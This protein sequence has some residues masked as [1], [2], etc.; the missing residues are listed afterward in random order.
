MKYL[1]N[2]EK[3]AF[4]RG[5]YIGYS[6]GVWRVRKRGAGGWE[7]EKFYPMTRT[8]NRDFPLIAAPTLEAMSTK[9]A[10]QG[11]AVKHCLAH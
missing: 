10:A 6:D 11:N 2:I 7:A 4:A 9:L 1:P 8:I 5:E 3:S